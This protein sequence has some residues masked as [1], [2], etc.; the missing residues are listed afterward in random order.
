MRVAVGQ[1]AGG[2][3]SGCGRPRQYHGIAVVAGTYEKNPGGLPYNT[4]VALDGR[5]SVV[6]CYRKSTFTTPSATGKATALRREAR[7]SRWCSIWMA[8]TL[9]PS[10]AT[11]SVFRRAPV[12]QPG[13]AQPGAAAGAGARQPPLRRRAPALAAGLG[14]RPGSR[15][16]AQGKVIE[17]RRQRPLGRQPRAVLKGEEGVLQQAGE[18]G[19]GEQQR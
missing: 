19:A 13:P 4:L 16:E 6:G 3:D 11:T 14:P 1:F 8:S 18:Q 9:V 10:R 2:M 5:G 7:G 17:F 12:P 15:L